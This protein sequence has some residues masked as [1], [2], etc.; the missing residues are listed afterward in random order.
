MDGSRGFTLLELLM[1]LA[2]ATALVVAGVPAY[3]TFIQNL[4]LRSATERLASDLYY[5]RHAAVNQGERVAVCPGVP[6][7][8]CSGSP[9]WEDGWLVF[10]D[11]NG[12]RRWQPGEPVLRVSP[13]LRGIR[14]RGSASRPEISFFANGTA[15]GSNATIRLCDGRG[16]RFGRQ[17][18]VSL[19]G[20]IRTVPPGDAG[21][22]C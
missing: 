17:V 9:A 11:E 18:R 19:T 1:T 13:L 20:R 6:D 10:N 5:A 2:I 8:G 12:D 4:E 15:P 16:A 21:L 14:A 7:R 3:R 22:D